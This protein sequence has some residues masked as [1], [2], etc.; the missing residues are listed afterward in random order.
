MSARM[1]PSVKSAPS[2]VQVLVDD[3]SGEWLHLSVLVKHPMFV[4]QKHRFFFKHPTYI[5]YYHMITIDVCMLFG[6]AVSI[7][8]I[9]RCL[10]K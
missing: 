2:V 3:L 6:V 10:L 4:I 7:Q 1:L 8:V 5:V 9:D